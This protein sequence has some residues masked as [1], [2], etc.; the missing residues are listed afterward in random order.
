MLKIFAS[1]VKAFVLIYIF[2]LSNLFRVCVFFLLSN[3]FFTMLVVACDAGI[4]YLF[5]MH[6]QAAFFL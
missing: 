3:M 5:N 1:L 6:T 4:L 2:A